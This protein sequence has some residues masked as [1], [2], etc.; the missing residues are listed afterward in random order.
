MKSF[1]LLSVAL[2]VAVVGVQGGSRRFARQTGWGAPAPAPGWGANPPLPGTYLP[3]SSH[4]IFHL[5]IS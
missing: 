3:Q 1:A 4:L 5:V 2:L